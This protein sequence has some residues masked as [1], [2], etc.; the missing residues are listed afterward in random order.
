[1]GLENFD[2][3]ECE[4]QI[5]LFDEDDENEEKSLTLG[6]TTY[7][8]ISSKEELSMSQRI[9][10]AKE[11]QRIQ[12]L[13]RMNVADKAAR[14]DF[15]V[16]IDYLSERF[17]EYAPAD[18]YRY[19]FGDHLEAPCKSKN[20]D[21]IEKKANVV[22]HI[23][24]PLIIKT[25]NPE[26]LKQQLKEIEEE[27][28]TY[29]EYNEKTGEVYELYG[30]DFKQIKYMHKRIM[31]NDYKLYS[32]YCSFALCGLFTSWGASIKSTSAWELYG[33]YIDLDGTDLEH[34]MYA[35][36]WVTG[37]A[38]IPKPTFIVNSGHGLHLY[39]IFNEPIACTKRNMKMIK[40]LKTKMID[41]LW[42]KYTSNIPN[43]Q[44][45]SAYQRARMVGS[46]TKLA[47]KK[48]KTSKYVLRAFKT[49]DRV[50]IDYLAKLVHFDLEGFKNDHL[51]LEEAKK[52]YPKWWQSVQNNE[53]TE[54][55]SEKNGWTCNRAVYD[56]WL[57]KIKTDP[58]L[59]IGHRYYTI[60]C[61]FVYAAKCGIPFSEVEEDAYG[62]IDMMNDIHTF[63]YSEKTHAS[64]GKDALFTAEDVRAASKMYA[65][66]WNTMSINHISH[67]TGLTIEKNKRRPKPLCRDDG[68][69]FRAARFIQ[70]LNDPN[71]EWRKG[72]GRKPKQAIVQ[73]WKAEHPDGKKADCIRDTGLDKKTV[74][75][76]W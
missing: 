4:G 64:Y 51:T 3:Y 39:Y 18:F 30:T 60:S 69:A 23:E 56:W 1:M 50:T 54:K 11:V 15:L 33:L 42:N 67:I 8:G 63:S 45:S 25:K 73:Q 46:K 43:R 59:T 68:S 52:K 71:G 5:S 41:L 70:E 31:L 48:S 10:R 72:N 35:V 9:A 16:K 61:L 13:E 58:D 36:N 57:N 66:N 2:D 12:R 22:Y 17:E 62:L 7:Y 55:K 24:Q 38:L 27:R 28:K 40:E 53:N 75:K 65:D 6:K 74:Y 49:G 14:E 76:W 32:D 29:I 20:Y 34:F 21:T 44:Y 37:N 26:K 19:I 47:D